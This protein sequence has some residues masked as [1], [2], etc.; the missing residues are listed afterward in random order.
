MKTFILLIVMLCMLPVFAVNS[1]S[2]ETQLQQAQ[3]MDVCRDLIQQNDEDLQKNPEL[4]K[5]ISECLAP[6]ID[7]KSEIALK[8]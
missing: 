1:E 2:T 7:E 3:E 8:Q 4:L 6:K 5:A